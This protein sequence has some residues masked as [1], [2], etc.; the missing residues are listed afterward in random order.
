MRYDA[1]WRLQNE[2][3]G[4]WT[5]NDSIFESREVFQNWMRK[6]S[7]DGY[8]IGARMGQ[9]SAHGVVF[10]F[11]TTNHPRINTELFVLKTVKTKN[12]QPLIVQ[13]QKEAFIG[14]IHNA[15]VPTVMAHRLN[16]TGNYEILMRNLIKDTDYAKKYSSSTMID[17]LTDNNLFNPQNKAKFNIVLRKFNTVLVNFYKTTQHFHGDLHL[18]NIELTFDKKNPDMINKIFIIDLGSVVPF[19]I[20]RLQMTHKR[21]VINFMN[22][23]S[24]AF[25]ALRERDNFNMVDK[26]TEHG[27]I[28]WLQD[29]K[30]SVIH[31]LK[32]KMGFDPFWR[33]LLLLG[34][35]TLKRKSNVLTPPK[36]L[37]RK[38][39]VIT[40]PTQRSKGPRWGSYVR[41]AF[42]F[43]PF[44]SDAPF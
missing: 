2:N 28:A 29:S 10:H 30:T 24:K 9:P 36:G 18:K 13:L 31:N 37:K 44:N 4:E 8:R 26:N 3:Y 1:S 12:N 16:H 7:A 40:P 21:F 19:L 15:P 27:N 43:I 6:M 17:Y 14:M 11:V 22:D 33:E 34:K 39:N 38:L 5:F 35:K 20:S 42:T 41:R 32:Q 25:K 23:I